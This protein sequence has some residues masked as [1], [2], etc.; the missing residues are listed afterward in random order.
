MIFIKRL[1]SFIEISA[2]VAVLCGCAEQSGHTAADFDTLFP[3]RLA[4]KE[5]RAQI[6][7]ENSEKARGLM[8]R[9]DL[10]ENDGMLFVY[11]SPQ[12]VSFWMMNTPINLD[13]GFFTQ[14]GT[15]TQIK[16]MYANNLDSVP[17]SRDDIAY[18]L[19]MNAGWFERNAI[20]PP[21]K[22]DTAL[23]QKAINARKKK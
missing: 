3:M 22:L 21:A 4:N 5:F 1:A 2:A 7:V 6:A 23:L 19:E 11:D 9:K 13:I 10:P 15:L 12:K 18:C 17:S 14:D 16:R 20:L 8:F